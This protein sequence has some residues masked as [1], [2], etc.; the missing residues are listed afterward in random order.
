M[1]SNEMSYAMNGAL[2][3]LAASSPV[4]YN[5]EAHTREENCVK[6]C[7]QHFKKEDVEY[8]ECMQSCLF[9]LEKK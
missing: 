4:M 6:E 1:N 9:F 8:V 3:Q 5:F 2:V 7:L